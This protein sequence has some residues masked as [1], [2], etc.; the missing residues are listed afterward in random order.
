MEIVLNSDGTRNRYFRPYIDQE[1]YHRN[2][3]IFNPN[4]PGY[5][6]RLYDQPQIPAQRWIDHSYQYWLKGGKPNADI[7]SFGRVYYRR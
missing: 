4:G 1:E 5:N 3:N 6:C 2:V 7:D